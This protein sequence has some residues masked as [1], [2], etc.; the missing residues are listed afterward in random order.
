[1][2]EVFGRAGLGQAAA[3]L[4]T[5]VV[6]KFGG[7]SL[8]DAVAIRR[9][10]ASSSSASRNNPSSRG[11]AHSPDVTDQLLAAGQAAA[12]GQAGIRRSVAPTSLAAAPATGA[13]GSRRGGFQAQGALQPQLASEFETTASLAACDLH[14]RRADPTTAGSIH[15]S[16]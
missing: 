3:T 2:S 15:R 7:T 10:I 1:M 8:A 6:M 14:F 5:S 11:P 16:G 4:A 9:A 13:G 12:S